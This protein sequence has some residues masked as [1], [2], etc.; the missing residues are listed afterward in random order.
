[1]DSGVGFGS[2]DAPLTW[3]VVHG[4]AANQKGSPSAD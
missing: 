4:R 2:A 3:N 1:M